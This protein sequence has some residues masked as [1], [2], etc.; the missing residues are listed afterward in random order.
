MLH[1]TESRN[2][3]IE[4]FSKNGMLC[5]SNK[6]ILFHYVTPLHVK[7]LRES[8]VLSV[9]FPPVAPIGRQKLD[10][11]LFELLSKVSLSHAL[12][13]INRVQATGTDLKD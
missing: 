11:P 9:L 7:G 3:P 8:V 2:S 10:V 4:S 5:H 6:S 1:L 12:F 13:V